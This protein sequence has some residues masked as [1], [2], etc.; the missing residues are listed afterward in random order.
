[1]TIQIPDTDLR[2]FQLFSTLKNCV[3]CY[4]MHNG[5]MG[6]RSALR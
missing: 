6:Y 3:E 1:M 4:S 5:L 2:Y